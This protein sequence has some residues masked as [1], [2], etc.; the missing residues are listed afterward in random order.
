MARQQSLEARELAAA[1]KRQRDR[2]KKGTVPAGLA[3]RQRQLTSARRE[4]STIRGTGVSSTAQRKRAQTAVDKKDPLLQM[5]IELTRRMA[6]AM[7][8]DEGRDEVRNTFLKQIADAV[9]NGT[10]LQLR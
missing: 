6:K 3:L 5:Q 7:E 1:K 9:K 8:G 2:K 10:P 4:L